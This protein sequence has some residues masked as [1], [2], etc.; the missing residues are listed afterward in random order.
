MVN[1]FSNFLTCTNHSTLNDVI[2]EGRA[3]RRNYTIGNKIIMD[4]FVNGMLNL[5]QAR[6]ARLLKKVLT[7]L[8]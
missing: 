6:A 3:S 1:F 8:R 7:E 5:Y 4:E 2:G